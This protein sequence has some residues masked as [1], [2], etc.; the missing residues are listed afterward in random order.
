MLIR[1][2]TGCGSSRKYEYGGQPYGD[3]TD[4]INLT[5]LD[6]QLSQKNHDQVHFY[7]YLHHC[8]YVSMILFLTYTYD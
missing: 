6:I 8:Y 1:M 2:F 4:S 3:L 7:H 5:V